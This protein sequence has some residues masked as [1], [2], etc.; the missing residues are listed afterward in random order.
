[1]K[2]EEARAA[3]STVLN[4]RLDDDTVNEMH[5]HI[6]SCRSCRRRWHIFKEVDTLL[7]TAP[8]RRPPPGFAARAASVAISARRRQAWLMGA[9]ALIG[10]GVFV[11]LLF[12]LSELA[13]SGA[14]YYLL[15]IPGVFVE[16]PELTRT[17]IIS[18]ISVFQGLL[19]ILQA[20][21]QLLLG[22]L[23]WPT[24]ILFGLSWTSLIVAGYL[25]RRWLQ[26][27]LQR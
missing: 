19:S 18:L 7:R 10:G 13:Q 12:G 3:I 4:R 27:D 2:C 15:T 25:S 1:M 11:V 6:R 20:I 17:L 26:T 8:M 5:V 23:L 22:P 16:L 9:L 21:Q 24:L 14:L